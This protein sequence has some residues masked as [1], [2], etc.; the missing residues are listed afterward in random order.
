MINTRSSTFSYSPTYDLRS[1][2]W[3]FQTVIVTIT[4]KVAVCKGEFLAG[5]IFISVT[6]PFLAENG[7]FR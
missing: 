2:C 1:S 6:D 5:F 3:L 7:Y 4:G